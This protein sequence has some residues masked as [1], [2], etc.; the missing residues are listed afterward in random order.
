MGLIRISFLLIILLHDSE[1]NAQTQPWPAEA[2]DQWLLAFV[3][4][5]T[6]GLIPAYH[7]MIDIGVVITDLAGVE[8][9]QL[10]L[11]IQPEY[12]ERTQEGARAVNAFNADRWRELNALSIDASVDRIVS[13]HKDIAGDKR[14][15]MVAFN[16]HF[17]AAFLDHHFRASD[18][19]WREI[20]HYFVL[21]LPSMAWSRGMRG[22]T[23]QSLAA[24]LG[25]EDEPHVSDLHTGITGA[26]L[27]ARIY[28]AI[29]EQSL[30]RAEQ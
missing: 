29:L 5:E 4:V 3:D 23:G 12:P 28:R 10:F 19:S 18:R 20:Y 1:V 16:S 26:L 9:G 25:V 24:S 14:V 6:T 21:D 8:Q 22:L 7:E 2:P 15:M 17:D 11:R 27:N 13:F 30:P